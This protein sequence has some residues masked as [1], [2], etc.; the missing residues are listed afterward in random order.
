[1]AFLEIGIWKPLFWLAL[2]TCSGAGGLDP[3]IEFYHW[4]LIGR[5]YKGL[6][7]PYLNKY[8][9]KSMFTFIYWRKE[10][11][12]SHPHRQSRERRPV[13]SGVPKRPGFAQITWPIQSRL[14]LYMAT[15]TGTGSAGDG[16]GPMRFPNWNTSKF[17]ASLILS[18]SNATNETSSKMKHGCRLRISSNQSIN[19]TLS[20]YQ[21]K[22]PMKFRP[23]PSFCLER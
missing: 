8:R 10:Y 22:R 6:L 18:V 9:S 21:G 20:L 2:L 3:S 11:D 12:L 7:S 16:T 4:S 15:C 5:S 14:Q 17:Q 1:V 13:N 19:H 23:G